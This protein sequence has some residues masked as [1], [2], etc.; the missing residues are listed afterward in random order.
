[1]SMKV[2]RIPFALSISNVRKSDG[3]E[4]IHV[5]GQL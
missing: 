2:V 3:V 4:D 1:M 5:Q